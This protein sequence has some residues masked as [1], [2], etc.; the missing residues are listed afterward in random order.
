MEADDAA[1]PDER[2]VGP[3]VPGDLRKRVPPVDEQEVHLRVPEDALHLID[4]GLLLGDALHP[5][6]QTRIS[7]HRLLRDALPALPIDPD[8]APEQIPPP[9]KEFPQEQRTARLHP[10]F[11]DD[12]GGEYVDDVPDDGELE[13]GL[14]DTVFLAEGPDVLRQRGVHDTPSRAPRTVGVTNSG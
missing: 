12:A 4:R 10:D 2:R 8:S 7:R 14:R 1:L 6:R 13:R 11:E 5:E 3:E 9:G